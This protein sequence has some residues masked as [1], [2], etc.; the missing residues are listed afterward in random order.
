MIIFKTPQPQQTFSSTE[1][2]FDGFT[3]TNIGETFNDNTYV[4]P[5]SVAPNYT[6]FTPADVKITKKGSQYINVLRNE[7]T[8]YIVEDISKLNDYNQFIPYVSNGNFIWE[9]SLSRDY[10]N[11]EYL[12]RTINTYGNEYIS[13]TRGQI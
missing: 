10:K 2:D 3:Y 6:F 5:Q 7:G 9:D 12:E 11:N 1:L 13:I 4:R 8:P